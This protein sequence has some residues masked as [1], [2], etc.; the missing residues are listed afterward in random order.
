MAISCFF[1]RVHSGPHSG[2][3]EKALLTQ[4]L[5]ISY[6]GMFRLWW[7]SENLPFFD[8]K[9]ATIKKRKRANMD[10]IKMIT[11]L[12]EIDGDEMTH[13]IWKMI[14]NHLLV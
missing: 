5:L 1:I 4:Y 8:N 6:L 13:V 2:D 12:V 3:H 11:P 14:K 10:K 9:N 7:H